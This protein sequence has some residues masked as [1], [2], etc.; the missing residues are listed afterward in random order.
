MHCSRR[1]IFVEDA[2]VDLVAD[3]AINEFLTFDQTDSLE[4]KEEVQDCGNFALYLHANAKRW[5]AKKNINVAFGM[6]WTYSTNIKEGH[7][8]N[9]F[10]NPDFQVRYRE[11][12]SDHKCFLDAR[13]KLVII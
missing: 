11:P 4:W 6:I 3:K 5:F 8:F 9:F 2:H 7:A 10:I 13:V 12:Q 1:R